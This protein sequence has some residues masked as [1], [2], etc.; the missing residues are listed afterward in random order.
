MTRRFVRAAYHEAGHALVAHV[1]GFQIC[2]VTIV[3]KD[4]PEGL[5]A[6]FAL[7]MIP[8]IKEVAIKAPYRAW[9]L[10][11]GAGA[12]LVAGQMTERLWFGAKT[13]RDTSDHDKAKEY[14]A[15]ANLPGVTILRCEHIA[16]QR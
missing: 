6:G 2:S 11:I 4:I 9:H 12:V 3:P 16:R 10:G 15:L 8:D 1:L 5:L 7:I 13:S 14:L